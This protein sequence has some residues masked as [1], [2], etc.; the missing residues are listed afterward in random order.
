[1]TVLFSDR[2]L[3]SRHLRRPLTWIGAASLA[4]VGGAWA[5]SGAMSALDVVNVLSGSPLVKP[6]TLAYGDSQRQR[7]DIYPQQQG[8]RPILIWF[9]GGAW[10]SGSRTDYRFVARTFHDLGYMVAIPDYRLTPEVVYPDFVRDSAAA[11]RAV[12]D[13]AVRFGGD[14]TRV[15]LAGHSAG[16]YN[17]AMV[18][19][20]RRWLPIAY[21]KRIRG[22]IGL[23][24][25]VNFLPIQMPEARQAFSWPDTPRD[26]QPVEHVSRESPPM[27][28]ISAKH[29]P[30]VDPDINAGVL[31]GRLRRLGVQV[32]EERLEDPLG[33]ITHARLVATLSNRMAPLVPTIA[34]MDAFAQRVSR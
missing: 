18:A 29:D 16:A 5:A 31:A 7:I 26:S 1:M 2:N 32:E 25:P 3:F 15:L 12:I 21:R 17:A 27:L 8:G 9:Y 10:N 30:L 20:D 11:V 19:L 13:E 14:P 23:A 34:R 33:F 28:L 22:V 6:F 24:A 4:A